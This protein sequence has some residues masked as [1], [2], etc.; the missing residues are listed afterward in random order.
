MHICYFQEDEYSFTF[1]G[2]N[3]QTMTISPGGVSSSGSSRTSSRH[4]ALGKR[5]IKFEDT[6]RMHAVCKEENVTQA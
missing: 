1:S 2:S 5:I 4:S 3:K 6:V